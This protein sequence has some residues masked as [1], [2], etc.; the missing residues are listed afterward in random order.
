MKAALD[1][2]TESVKNSDG[3]IVFLPFEGGN[4]DSLVAAAK[5]AGAVGLALYDPT[6]AEGEEYDYVNVELTNYD[7]P[8]AR[9]N[10]TEFNWMK[11]NNS[12]GTVS[13]KA[14]WNRNNAAG[15]MSSFSVLGPD[16]RPLPEAGDHRHRR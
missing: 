10:L 16:G 13:I 3:K 6:P 5:A 1:A 8:V 15:E 14:D 4:A 11:Q 9:V 7:V 2:Y 12:T